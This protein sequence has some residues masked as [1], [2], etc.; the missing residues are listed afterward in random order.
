M[1]F[2]PLPLS[3]FLSSFDNYM[4]V[5]LTVCFFAT[6]VKPIRPFDQRLESPRL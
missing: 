3:L 4:L 1:G 6:A 2:S 5:P